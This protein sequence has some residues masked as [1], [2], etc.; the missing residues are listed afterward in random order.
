MHHDKTVDNDR[1]KKSAI[2]LYYNDT[3]GGV[4]RMNH[5]L[6]TDS[7]QRKTNRWP[8]TFFNM[9]DIA[10]LAAFVVW[11]T[12]NPQWNIKLRRRRRVFLLDIGCELISAQV[13]RRQ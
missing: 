10:E 9:L 4:D 11:T 13:S 8:M 1:R 6:A 5:T 2:I 7:C 12:K 3:R